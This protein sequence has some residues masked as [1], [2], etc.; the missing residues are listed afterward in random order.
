[1]PCRTF[2]Q[3]PF[4]ISFMPAS[5]NRPTW[6]HS[7]LDRSVLSQRWILWS[8]IKLFLFNQFIN[9]FE[10]LT[11][12]NCTEKLSIERKWP[13]TA[14]NKNLSTNAIKIGSLPNNYDHWY[15]Y[16]VATCL[17]RNCSVTCWW[18]LPNLN[19]LND[20]DPSLHIFDMN[21]F[22]NKSIF[23]TPACKLFGDWCIIAL[24]EKHVNWTIYWK[25][26]LGH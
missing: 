22:I 20:P 9:F 17:T 25:A 16:L 23:I 12:P 26:Q 8:E 3:L 5:G 6:L 19:S 14:N 1:M 18:C 11:V 21:T 24:P 7:F 2:Q 10:L 13:V 4:H 15:K